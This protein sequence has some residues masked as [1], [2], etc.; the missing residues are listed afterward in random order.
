MK[1][2]IIFIF[3]IILMLCVSGLSLNNKQN[4]SKTFADNENLVITAKSALLL[5]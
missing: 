4:I 1:K 2:P 5:D 3:A